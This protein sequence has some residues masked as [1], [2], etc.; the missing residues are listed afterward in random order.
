MLWFICLKFKSREEDLLYILVRSKS[1]NTCVLKGAVQ[2][3]AFM[4]QKGRAH[5]EGPSEAEPKQIRKEGPMKRLWQTNQKGKTHEGAVPK[6]TRKGGPMKR[7]CTP[8]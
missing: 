3:Q 8:M 7:L 6:Q 1:Q 2:G 4:D 5:H